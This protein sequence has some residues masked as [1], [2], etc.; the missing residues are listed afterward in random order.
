MFK[1]LIKKLVRKVTKNPIAVEAIS[2]KADDIIMDALDSQ[3][4]GLATRIDDE[5]R[6][7]RQKKK[8]P[9]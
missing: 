5:A 9:F 3:T 1:K 8:R 6:K 7:I 2:E 4:G